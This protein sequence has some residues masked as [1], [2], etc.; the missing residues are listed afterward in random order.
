MWDP[1]VNNPAAP[2]D[3]HSIMQTWLQNYDKPQLQSIEGGWTVDKNLNG[4]TVAHVFS[5]YT[6]NGYTK[7]ATIWVG[8]TGCTKAGF[9]TVRPFFPVSALMV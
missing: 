4:D 5:Y 6:T 3:D 8:T 2:G 7:M 9:S 1:T